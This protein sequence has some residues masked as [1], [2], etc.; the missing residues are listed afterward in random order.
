MARRCGRHVDVEALIGV[1][2]VEG[3]HRRLVGIGADA[4]RAAGD[5][6]LQRPG[7]RRASHPRGERHHHPRNQSC[8]P[9]QHLCFS[10]A[11]SIPRCSRCAA[12]RPAPSCGGRTV[13]RSSPR[14]EADRAEAVAA[15]R[16]VVRDDPG[17]RAPK[18]RSCYRS[19]RNCRSGRR[20]CP[21]SAGRAWR[22][23]GKRVWRR[24]SRA[25]VRVRASG[26]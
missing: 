7:Q 10:F 6:V 18:R 15:Q 23:G 8:D 22:S 24:T 16:A 9:F 21:A 20:G 5:D 25:D 12:R 3:G 11:P 14:Q 19:A 2:V 26:H 13:L 1:V 4:Q 17:V